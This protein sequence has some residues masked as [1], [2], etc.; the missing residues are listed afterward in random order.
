MIDFTLQEAQ[1]YRV[2]VD[3]FG[4][5]RVVPKMRVLAICG[6]T[7][8]QVA[9]SGQPELELWANENKCLFTI[10]NEQDL[11]RLVIEFFSGFEE[12]VEIQDVEHQR[13]LP[14][15]LKAAGV[16]YVTFS[17]AEFSEL[18]DPHSSLDFVTLLKAKVDDL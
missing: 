12:S 6:G 8:P 15:L 10:V 11:P 3:F 5:D 7:L 18:L 1:F 16:Q 9:V 14:R 2:L 4:H 13:Y 17:L